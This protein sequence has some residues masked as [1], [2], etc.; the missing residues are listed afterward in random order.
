LSWPLST[1]SVGACL[2]GGGTPLRFV[3]DVGIGK[4][5]TLPLHPK[6]ISCAKYAL[7]I[8]TCCRT[9]RSSTLNP[10]TL[11][12]VRSV[13]GPHQASGRWGPVYARI[14]GFE[15]R[16]WKVWLGFD[17]AAHWEVRD[18][19]CRA[20]RPAPRARRRLSSTP[21]LPADPACDQA[22]FTTFVMRTDAGA[23]QSGHF[24][25]LSYYAVLRPGLSSVKFTTP[26]YHVFLILIVLQHV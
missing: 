26:G 20:G 7:G 15:L 3:Q 4:N 13:R 25:T 23:S 24:V 18:A 22:T 12:R 2:F 14:S 6:P 16:G 8:V 10:V 17:F 1:Q 9:L 5:T 11:V 19:G 21:P